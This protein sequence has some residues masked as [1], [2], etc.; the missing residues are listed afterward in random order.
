MSG[1]LLR[2]RSVP[3]GS[4][5]GVCAPAGP[6]EAD[7]VEAGIGWLEGEGYQVRCAPGLKSRNGY[8]AGSDEERCAELIEKSLMLCTPLAPAIGYDRAAAIAKRAHAEKKTV[9]EV[10]TEMGI[11]DL[12]ERLDVRSMT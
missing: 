3:R 4:T 10:A 1:C 6:V 12:D 5:I 2:P 11:E 9:R 7:V 8:L